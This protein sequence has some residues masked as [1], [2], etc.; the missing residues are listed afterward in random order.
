V[1]LLADE[2]F[3]RPALLA[4]RAAGVDVEAVAEIMPGASDRTVLQHAATTNRWLLTLDRDYGELVFLRAVASP[5]AII[6]LRIGSYAPDWAAQVV[7]SLLDR[8]EFV[9][10]HL[11]VVNGRTARRRPLPKPSAT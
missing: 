7:L 9:N 8:A 6:Y 3:P 4:L 11:V 5:P 2:N 10:G 1:R